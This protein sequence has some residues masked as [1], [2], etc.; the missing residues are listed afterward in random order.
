[1]LRHDA[2][3]FTARGELD[4]K[5]RWVS[6]ACLRFQP[7]GMVQAF[8]L[9]ASAPE[10][11]RLLAAGLPDAARGMWRQDGAELAFS[12][13]S[14]EGVIE[15]RGRIDG[16]RLHLA[17]VHRA[18]GRRDE[19]EYRCV[20]VDWG[21]TAA[22]PAGKPARK[23][24]AQLP[25]EPLRPRSVSAADA[26]KWYLQML[27]RLPGLLDARQAAAQQLAQA[28]Q[29]KAQMRRIAAQAHA[30]AAAAKEFLAQW[31]LP[32]LE[33]LR[34]RALAEGHAGA[35]EAAAL[36]ALL[37]VTQEELQA[38]PGRVDAALGMAYWDGRRHWVLTQEGWVAK[39]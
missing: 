20:H 2:V 34:E 13:S 14:D 3:Y 11:P 24:D 16:S 4:A 39:E 26:A 19:D 10:L 28:W 31:P 12:V 35:V 1:V 6:L 38:L 5:G 8:G 32:T 36:Q 9:H 15:A 30:D 29:L 33:Q 23:R 7:D 17:T 25:F 18:S 22:A 37:A 21:Q 27:A